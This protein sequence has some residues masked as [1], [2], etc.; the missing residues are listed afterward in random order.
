MRIDTELAE[1]K[2][3]AL[4]AIVVTYFPTHHQVRCLL[5]NLVNAVEHTVIVDNTPT[6]TGIS[7]YPRIE[8]QRERVSYISLPTNTG[9]AKAQ[10][11]GILFLQTRKFDGFLFLDQDSSPTEEVLVSLRTRLEGLLRTHNKV[12]AIGPTIIREKSPWISN[13]KAGF[14]ENNSE[15]LSNT[16]EECAFIISSG[17]LI[18]AHC[19]ASVG[20]FR[21][22]LFIDHVDTEW[23]FRA[24]AL[25]W[26]IYRDP[27]A[28]MPHNLGERTLTIRIHRPFLIAL[29]KPERYYYQARNIILITKDGTAPTTWGLKKL[30]ATG[31]TATL[32]GLVQGTLFS[33]MKHFI[34]GVRSGLIQ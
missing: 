9:I 4:G 10:N 33:S 30:F 25:G 28:L 22:D 29:H 23:M 7:N 34:R 5:D 13:N 26:K 24:S 12:G 31:V 32:A 16:P 2:R 3:L 18:T 27:E 21:E 14:F 11:T 6:D 19:L 15:K 20:L 1:K 17:S 8:N